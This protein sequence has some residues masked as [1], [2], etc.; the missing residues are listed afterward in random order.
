LNERL[1]SYLTKPE[2]DAK[3]TSKFWDDEHISKGMLDAHLNPDWDAASR[4]HAFVSKSVDWIAGLADPTT[5]QKLLDLGCGPGLYAERFYHKGYQVTGIDYSRRSI[6]YATV[7][8]TE[9]NYPITYHYQNY[10]QIAYQ[11]QFDVVT[12]IYCD[13]CVLPEADRKTLL[14]N[15]YCA[16][17]A[18]GKFIV[19]VNT[20]NVY[21]GRQEEKSW[22]Y[23]ETGF[24]S[25]K[26]HLCLNAFYRYEE[27]NTFLEQFVIV[28]E[29]SVN[30]YYNWDHTLTLGD[31]KKELEE[32]GFQKISF[33]ADVAGAEYKPESKT[34]CAVAIK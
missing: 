28:T 24:W 27:Y 1:L 3:S 31:L 8:A 6:N 23:S 17:K 4:K 11:E 21:Q 20:P 9:K 25:D 32:A 30:S 19:D 14:H 7:A 5:H 26:P 13:Y 18:K 10:L 34:L 33:Y 29:N 22:D 12:L 16:M 2:M 15:A